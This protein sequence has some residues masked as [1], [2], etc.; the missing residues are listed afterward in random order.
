MSASR[1]QI[2]IRFFPQA[3][4]KEKAWVRE[5]AVAK[6]S[7]DGGNDEGNAIGAS[8]L[9]VLAFP[10]K[11]REYSCSHKSTQSSVSDYPDDGDLPGPIQVYEG[12]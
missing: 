4:E 11:S 3:K 7:N 1:R 12:L 6:V 9:D 8:F 2:Q 10:S 5:R